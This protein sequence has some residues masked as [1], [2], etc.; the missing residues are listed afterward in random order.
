M[1][2]NLVQNA[3]RYSPE[4]KEIEMK[5]TRSGSEVMLE[6]ADSGLGIA[7]EF[8]QEIFEKFFRIENDVTNSQGSGLG[9]FLVKHAVAA[10]G[11]RIEVQ[12]RIGAGGEI[13]HPPAL[14]R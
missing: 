9:L 13:H 3:L 14:G 1:I 2:G 5:V 10:H 4:R 7:P 6:V 8:Q 11:G 12:E